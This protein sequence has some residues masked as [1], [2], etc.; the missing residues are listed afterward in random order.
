MRP[1]H[2][3]QGGPVTTNKHTPKLSGSAAADADAFSDA[4][5][6]ADGPDGAA[7]RSGAQ[8]P[9][10]GASVAGQARRDAD[11]HPPPGPALISPAYPQPAFYPHDLEYP[12][13]PG[14]L[15]VSTDQAGP[16]NRQPTPGQP[17]YPSGP[18]YALDAGYELDA[19]Y[20]RQLG[21]PQDPGY[22]PD[23]GYG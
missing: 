20:T 12:Q 8:L 16:R 14:Y 23:S 5:V 19:G 11:P 1:T 6:P 18:G 21:Y 4:D 22:G 13:G 7:G 10:E 3:D 17:G 15:P 2:E 9:E